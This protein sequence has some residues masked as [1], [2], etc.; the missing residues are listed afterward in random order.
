MQLL[1]STRSS[2][3]ADPATGNAIRIGIDNGI[4]IFPGGVP[5]YRGQ[6]IVGAVGVSGDGVDQDDMIA[7]LGLARTGGGLNNAAAAIRVSGLKFVQCPQSPLLSEPSAQ[8]V[9]DGI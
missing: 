3:T 2:C 9:C 7:A 1:D 5:V 4:Q 6:N 8:N